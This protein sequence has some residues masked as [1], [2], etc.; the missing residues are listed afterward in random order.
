[1]NKFSTLFNLNKKK[2][3]IIRSSSHKI[4]SKLF[5][6]NINK[7][8][9]GG[10]RIKGFFKHKSFKEP[11]ITVITVVKDNEKYLEETIRSVLAQKY[12]NIEYLI[13]DG[14][15]KDKTR[16][17]IKKYENYIDYWVSKKDKG[18]YDAFNTGLSLSNGDYIGF[19]NSDDI[20]TRNAMKYLGKYLKKN[21]DFI[22]GSVKKHWG[23]LHGFKPK[24]IWYT[25]GFYTSHSSGFFINHK[26]M[27]KVGKYN[28]KYK[29]SSDYDYLYRMI[30]KYKLN[31]IAS[32][33]EEIFGIFRRG[34]Y[35]STIP[36]RKHFL[37]EIKI[38][39]DNGQNLITLFFISIAKI[40]F[41][42]KRFITNK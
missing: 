29:Y 8:N 21:Y 12:K 38:R 24:K 22:F 18:I 5:L 37:E 14:N 35:S 36:F 7:I 40:F 31:G 9:Q 4:N 6:N 27:Q 15:S 10:L 26:A 28:L 23:L 20:F 34:G 1:M 11:L 3:V 25:W 42:F 19:L 13:I 39:K 16:K 30:V 17:I 33:K 2:P 32:K 41:N